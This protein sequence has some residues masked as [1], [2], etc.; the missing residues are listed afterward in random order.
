M[1]IQKEIQL[2]LSSGKFINVDFEIDSE[3]PFVF[4][5]S[6][7]I[8]VEIKNSKWKLGLIFKY[9]KTENGKPP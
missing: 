7:K 1:Q 3:V 2:Y 6:F 9:L 8:E 5:N 4:Y